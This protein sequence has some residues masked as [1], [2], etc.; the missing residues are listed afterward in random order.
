MI[1]AKVGNDTIKP[2]LIERDYEKLL[3]DLSKYETCED[4]LGSVKGELIL[5]SEF[6]YLK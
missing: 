5:H 4:F 3:S 2:K 1:P 6:E